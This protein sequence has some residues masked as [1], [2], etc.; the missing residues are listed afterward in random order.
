MEQ[1]LALKA[2]LT[3]LYGSQPVSVYIHPITIVVTGTIYTD[4]YSTMQELGVPIT[5]ARSCAAKLHRIAVGYVDKI[6]TTK[7]QQE[8]ACKTG[9]G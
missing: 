2:A 8:R 3:N 4:F 1:H 6:I 9:V 5:K 7:W